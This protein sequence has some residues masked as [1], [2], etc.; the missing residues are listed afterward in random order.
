MLSLLHLYEGAQYDT[1][2]SR[3]SVAAKVGAG[4]RAGR[5][6]W[7]VLHKEGVYLEGHLRPQSIR[8]VGNLQQNPPYTCRHRTSGCQL[9]GGMSHGQLLQN[10]TSN[11]HW[12]HAC[13]SAILDKLHS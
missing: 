5:M 1:R 12:S 13:N 11:R 10:L 4:G 9:S 6:R 7:V 3:R 8:R 2:V